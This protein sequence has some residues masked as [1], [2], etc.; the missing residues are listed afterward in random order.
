MKRFAYIASYDNNVSETV[1]MRD[2]YWSPELSA[3][4]SSLAET[5]NPGDP[6][7]QGW[8]SDPDQVVCMAVSSRV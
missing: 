7:L 3:R 8:Y 6:I 1:I 4:F 5:R 2:R